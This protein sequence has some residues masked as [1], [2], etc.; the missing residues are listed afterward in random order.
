LAEPVADRQFTNT[1]EERI[2]QICESVERLVSTE[3]EARP[4]G[5][6]GV[7][8]YIYDA[9][10][11]Q[12][13]RPLTRAA[14][15]ALIDA[16][17]QKAGPVIV[18]TGWVIDFWFPAGEICGMTGAAALAR[19]ITL[20]LDHQVL[21][22]GEDQVIP[23]FAAVCGA[24][25]MRVYTPERR[26]ELPNV[27]LSDNFPTED[28]A[29]RECATRLLDEVDPAAIITIEK[30]SPNR[31]GIYHSGRGR[32]MTATSAKISVLVEEARKRGVLTVG[33]GD[34][35]NEIGFGKIRETVE[36][37]IP[38]GAECA[39]PCR[40]GIASDV[41]TDILVVASSSSRGGYGVEAAL[42]TL[43]G[44]PDVMHDGRTEERMIVAAA[45]AGAMDSYRVAPATS[46]GHGVDKHF[47]AALVE[48]LRQLVNTRDQDFGMYKAR[49]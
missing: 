15:E 11:A 32:D 40:G 31:H 35:G 30:C 39:C 13:D 38:R 19:A 41:A 21:F 14:A 49:G 10:R 33:I 48:L 23:V 22:L 7:L 28:A 16:C 43:L 45:Q 26:K 9:A 42:A 12:E 46:D 2:D 34:L 37:H 25:E 3:I 44:R 18:S 17:K 36:E 27:V 1:L 29:A 5:L 6:R 20:G 47:S 4:G 24:C 8:H